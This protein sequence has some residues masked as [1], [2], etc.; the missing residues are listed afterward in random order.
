MISATAMTAFELALRERGFTI[1]TSKT[2]RE[3]TW[4]ATKSSLPGNYFIAEISQGEFI[5]ESK[6]GGKIELTGFED[7]SGF[8]DFR[9]AVRIV[10]FHLYQ[11]RDTNQLN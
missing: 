10:D 4:T 7:F 9:L 2:D 11:S 6:V 1:S 3:L 5:L 8:E